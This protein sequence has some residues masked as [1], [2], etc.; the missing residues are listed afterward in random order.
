MIYILA[1]TLV[2]SSSDRKNIRFDEPQE[3][4]DLET[5]RKQFKDTVQGVERVNLEYY[6]K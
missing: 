4:E 2:F 1:A 5:F 3:V 6:E